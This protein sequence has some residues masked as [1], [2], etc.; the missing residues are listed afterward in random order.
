MKTVLA[1]I[2]LLFL[3]GA[4]QALPDSLELPAVTHYDLKLRLMPDDEKLEAT[5]KLRIKNHT[6]RDVNE[7]PLLLYRLL[8]VTK[9][10]QDGAAIPFSQDIVKFPDQPTRQINLITLKLPQPLASGSS[11]AIELG[12]SGW[13]Y[14]YPEVEAYV[15]DRIDKQYALIRRDAFSYP[16]LSTADAKSV[17]A[18]AESLFTFEVEATVPSGYTIACGGD[19]RESVPEKDWITF[20]Y[21]KSEPTWRIDIASSKFRVV[22]D[23]PNKLTVFAMEEDQQAAVRILDAMKRATAFYTKMFGPLKNFEGYT[24]IEIPDGWGSQAG[25]GYFLQT[26]AAFKDPSRIQEVFHE[27]AHSWN[28]EPKREVQRA[29]WFDEAF[30]S[31]FESL[32]VREYQGQKEFEAYMEKSRALF[33]QWGEYDKKNF[34]TPIVDYGKYEIGQNSYTKGAWSL[35]VLHRLI[36]EEKFRELIRTLRAQFEEKQADFHDFQ[37]AAE[38]IAGRSLATYFEEWFYGVESSRL[39]AD[40]IAVDEMVK[41]YVE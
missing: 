41:R 9:V 32:S 5:A 20:R 10:T 36:G 13:I 23:E 27:V 31:Y 4:D 24:A 15:K 35:Y 40:K 37:N 11:C 1:S 18:T 28:I 2:V 19:L 26:A 6:P 25:D 14:G 33:I 17:H 8:E 38:K 30:A 21:R 39:M 34:D 22:R 12:Y 3:L 16:I 7:I 29:R